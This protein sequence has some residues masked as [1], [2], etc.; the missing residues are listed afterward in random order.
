MDHHV[1]RRG[2]RIALPHAAR[3]IGDLVYAAAVN[4]CGALR[5]ATIARRS[6]T[7]AGAARYRRRPREG[8][9]AFL[10]TPA[11]AAGSPNRAGATRATR[12]PLQLATAR[13]RS[14]GVRGTL[15]ARRP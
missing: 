2:E 6:R 7:R 1:E 8:W 9:P 5:L 11:G 12:A 3:R 14:Q 4:H 10:R 15:P 13:R